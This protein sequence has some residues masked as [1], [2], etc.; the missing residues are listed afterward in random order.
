MT[1]CSLLIDGSAK[2]RNPALSPS[3]PFPADLCVHAYGKMWLDYLHLSTFPHF[4]SSLNPDLPLNASTCPPLA[5]LASSDLGDLFCYLFRLKNYRIIV[6]V[7]R[8][9]VATV[10]YARYQPMASAPAAAAP[11][12]APA[13]G[14]SVAAQLAIELQR[15]RELTRTLYALRGEPTPNDVA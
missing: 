1:R 4:F 9:Y 11:A 3:L 5:V 7:S 6:V 8:R 14:P 10:R 13:A 2:R 12:A 15:N